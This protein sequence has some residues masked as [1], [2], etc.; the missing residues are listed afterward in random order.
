[1]YV[2]SAYMQSISA[3][4]AQNNG[5]GEWDR[6]KKA[7]FYGIKTALIAGVLMGL[8]SFLCG[9]LLSAIFSGNKEVI[10]YAHSYLKAYAIDCILTA[11]LFV[12]SDISMVAAIP[13]L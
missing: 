6:S 4:V 1:M 10:V 7:L 8:L 13:Y 9:N 3:F 2:A 5:A 11:V 12:L